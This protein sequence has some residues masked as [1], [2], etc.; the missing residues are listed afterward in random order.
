MEILIYICIGICLH[1]YKEHV[2]KACCDAV[3][4]LKSLFHK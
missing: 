1:K 2:A 4:K 3:N